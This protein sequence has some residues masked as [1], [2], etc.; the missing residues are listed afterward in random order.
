[1]R[2]EVRKNNGVWHV[3]DSEAYAAID[4]VPANDKAEAQQI[5]DLLNAK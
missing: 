5:V 3:F 2:Y 4:V 1:M